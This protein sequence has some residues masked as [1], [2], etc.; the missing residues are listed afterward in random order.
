M[1]SLS[2]PGMR[3]PLK[4]QMHRGPRQNQCNLRSSK[5]PLHK[6]RR[7]RHKTVD[8]TPKMEFTPTCCGILCQRSLPSSKKPSSNPC[9]ATIMIFSSIANLMQE[10]MSASCSTAQYKLYFRILEGTHI[11]YG[12]WSALVVLITAILLP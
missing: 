7:I 10:D 3:M 9:S 4:K 11:R 8:H 6:C 2:C 12:V 1:Q 5:I